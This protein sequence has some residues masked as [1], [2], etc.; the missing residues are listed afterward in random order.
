MD[1]EALIGIVAAG[2]ALSGAVIG[3]AGAVWASHYQAKSVRYQT[4]AQVAAQRD[5]WLRERRRD[6]CVAFLTAATECEKCIHEL[7]RHLSGTDLPA[8]RANVARSIEELSRL[9]MVVRIEGPPDMV[10]LYENLHA[11]GF[12]L[13]MAAESQDGSYQEESSNFNSYRRRIMTL[14]QTKFTS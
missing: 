4:D 7:R 3:A 9:L 10:D 11:A 12:S 5:Q 1:S 13:L 8:V 14:G 6:T 2:A